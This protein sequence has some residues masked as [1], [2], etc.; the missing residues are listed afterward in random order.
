MRDRTAIRHRIRGRDE[1]QC[2][3][4]Y[5]L[6][7]LH[8]SQLQRHVQRGGTVDDRHRMTGAGIGRKIGLEAVNIAAH[9]GDEGGIQ[10]ILQIG[11][12]VAGEARLVQGGIALAHHIADGLDDPRDGGRW[13]DDG[14][15]RL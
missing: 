3:D 1:G 14:T 6:A 15:H 11:P 7:C 4:Q 13:C 9:R 8:A 12:L 10:A 2:R 5:F